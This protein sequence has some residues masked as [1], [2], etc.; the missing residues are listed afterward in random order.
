MNVEEK[1]KI[2]R[3]IKWSLGLK[4]GPVR[5][6]LILT[7]KCNQKCGYCYLREHKCPTENELTTEEITRL[8]REASKLGV[9][10]WNLMG[11]GE[12]M[13]D[14][15]KALTAVKEIKKYNMFGNI[16]TNGT[17]FNKEIIEKLVRVGWDCINFSIDSAE[18]D[19]QDYLRGQKGSFK[20]AE[21][22]LE[23]FK[24]TKLESKTTKPRIVIHSV[25]TK[26]N[27]DKI[28]ALMIFAKEKGADKLEFTQVMSFSKAAKKLRLNLEELKEFKKNVPGLV[29]LSKRLDLKTN[30][31]EYSEGDL[32]KESEN[33]DELIKKDVNN[34]KIKLN[35]FNPWTNLMVLN[36]GDVGPC[37]LYTPD[38]KIG[39]IRDSSLKEIWYGRK[40][41]EFRDK[42]R[43]NEI[44]SCKDCPSTEA[45]RNRKIRMELEK[46][47]IFKITGLVKNEL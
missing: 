22:A 35:C 10:N 43:N 9:Y 18:E 28:E 8:V 16:T 19:V 24:K 13:F 20:K 2:P 40:L 32:I 6:D 25:I 21:D 45:I 38:K 46:S 1:K 17:L 11:G 30:L 7:N 29:S 27:Y 23:L 39:N 42:I 4:S 36:N 37:C 34:H 44:S 33:M 14:Q 5:I 26:K 3:L 15:E 47:I 31:E 41:E 12:P